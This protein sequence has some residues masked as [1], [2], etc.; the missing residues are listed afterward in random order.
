MN[1]LINTIADEQ[2][3]CHK[4]ALAYAKVQGNVRIDTNEI[5]RALEEL[6]HQIGV[7]QGL[8]LALKTIQEA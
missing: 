7:V 5:K 8:E 1:S 3:K 4:L 2:A 6:R